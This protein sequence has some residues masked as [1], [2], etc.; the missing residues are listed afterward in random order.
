[1]TQWVQTHL[2]RA[3]NPDAHTMPD[4]HIFQQQRCTRPMRAS[5]GA[6]VLCRP[7][8]VM[9]APNGDSSRLL[10]PSTSAIGGSVFSRTNVRGSAFPRTREHLWSARQEPSAK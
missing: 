4:A 6:R 2:A 10:L 7:P 1:M 5:L 3:A 9:H 8:N